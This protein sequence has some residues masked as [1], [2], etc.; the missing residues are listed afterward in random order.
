MT[1][2]EEEDEESVGA[3]DT[4]ASS[5]IFGRRGLKNILNSGCGWVGPG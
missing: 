5:E 4:L 3:A 2:V 1:G